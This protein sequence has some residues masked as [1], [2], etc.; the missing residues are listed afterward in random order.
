MD[1]FR[2]ASR[3]SS[4]TLSI[5]RAF[6]ASLSSAEA[7]FARHANSP[8]RFIILGEIPMRPHLWTLVLCAL[9]GTLG[10][11]SNAHAWHL[12]QKC[13]A[14]S[15][16]PLA[17]HHSAVRHSAGGHSAVPH[18]AVRHSEV[19]SSEVRNAEVRNEVRNEVR[20]QAVLREEVRV[21][22]HPPAQVLLEFS[23]ACETALHRATVP[24]PAGASA[25]HLL[26]RWLRPSPQH[27]RRRPLAK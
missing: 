7:S 16:A 6:L 21:C 22:A 20:P 4:F 3:P 26:R 15:R 17:V 8:R 12:K 11:S 10:L 25:A 9:I 19:R 18:A 24:G 13:P 27:P 14:P 5:G 1:G 2:L 23:G